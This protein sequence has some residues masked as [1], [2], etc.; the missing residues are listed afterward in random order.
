MELEAA[1]AGTGAEVEANGLGGSSTEG[2]AASGSVE[3]PLLYSVMVDGVEEK[4]PFDELQKGY[5]RQSDYTKKTQGVAAE[6][7]ELQ[8]LKNLADALERDPR[9]TLVSL[10]GA[11][12][13]DFGTAKQMVAA[14]FGTEGDEDPVLAI[15]REVQTLAQQLRSRDEAEQ[16]SKQTAAQQAQVKLQIE[17]ELAQLHSGH[18]DFPDRELIAYALEHGISNLAKAYGAWQYD[19]IEVNRIAELNAATESKRQAQIV[20][21]GRNA[22]AG[23]LSRGTAGTRPSIREAFEMAKQSQ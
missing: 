17:G 2:E 18:G 6:K 3:E 5:M 4:V 22:S 15:R 10:A 13:V 8:Q 23:A 12:G 11:L 14:E 7:Q 1:E 21:G 19:A 16:A 9:G 20:A